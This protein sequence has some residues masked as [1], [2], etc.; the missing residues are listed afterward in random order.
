[1]S[2]LTQIVASD[3]I[4]QK[5][6]NSTF[7]ISESAKSRLID[8]AYI[9]KRSMSNMLETLIDSAYEN[10]NTN[11]FFNTNQEFFNA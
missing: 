6:A 1:M 4:T 7:S 8:L 10:K 3:E 2:E 11:Q 5:K 9:H